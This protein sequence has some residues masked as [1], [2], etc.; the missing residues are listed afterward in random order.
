MR[1]AGFS[2]RMV[3]NLIDSLVL[4]PAA[5]GLLWAMSLQG[6]ALFALLPLAL[7]RPAYDIW[8]HARSGQTPG[9]RFAGIR[10]VKLGGERIS[11]REAVLRSSVDIVFALARTG[12]M[13][14]AIQQFSSAEADLGWLDRSRL[15]DEHGPVW[16]AF[17]KYASTAWYWSELLFLLL[18]DKRRA[19]HDF[20]AGTVVSYERAEGALPDTPVAGSA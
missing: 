6:P 13:L 2:S 16:G 7:V 5:L 17:V 15:I 11:W 14:V 10:V 4:L 8:Y 9:K 1:Y 19:L 20:I 12:A 18:N 3:A